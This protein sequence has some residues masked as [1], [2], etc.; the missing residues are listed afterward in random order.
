MAIS[1]YTREGP[2]GRFFFLPTSGVKTLD[3]S[4]L[5]YAQDPKRGPGS[6]PDLSFREI[7]V[8]LKAVVPGDVD[9]RGFTTETNQ[10]DLPACVGNSTADSIEIL[11]A[12][13]GFPKVELSRMFI[14]TLAR[15]M[16]TEEGYKYNT[17]TYIRLAFKVLN[18]FGIC[19]EEHYPYSSA[20]DRLPS[21]KAMQKATG[22]KIK[23]YYRIDSTGE[24]RIEDMLKALRARHPVVFG[25][26]LDDPWRSYRGQGT[27]D[28]PKGATIGGHAMVCVGY[29]SKKG[30]IVKNSWGRGWGDGGFCYLSEEYMMWKSTWDIWVPTIGEDFGK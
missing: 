3:L 25:T 15:N 14:W 10:L 24:Q 19:L 6:K 17:G 1:L 12:A 26:L 18:K 2:N 27:L 7:A 20:W 22:R 30:F 13:Q 8:G 21:L 5:N 9:L 16:M 29:D 23:G 28:V 11:S 4:T